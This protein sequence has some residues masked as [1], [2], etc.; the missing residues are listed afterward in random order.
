MQ[1]EMIRAPRT[2]KN[3]TNQQTSVTIISTVLTIQRE[4]N[5]PQV[6]FFFSS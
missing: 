2:A 3:N 4:N 5:Q 6:K 1:I